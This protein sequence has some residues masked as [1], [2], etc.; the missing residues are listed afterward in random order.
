MNTKQNHRLHLG[1]RI[2]T[3]LKDY[4]VSPNAVARAIG[5]KENTFFG[6]LKRPSMQVE[7]LIQLSEVLQY[8]FVMDIALSLDINRHQPN[9]ALETLKQ[10]N[11]QLKRKN[12]DLELQLKTILE[13]KR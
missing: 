8:N 1:K 10:E 3:Y 13:L 2:H 11:A 5:I 6:T 7:R 12:E 4:N 9:K